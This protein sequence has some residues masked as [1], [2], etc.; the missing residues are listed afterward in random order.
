MEAR[1]KASP[2]TYPENMRGSPYVVKA[3]KLKWTVEVSACEFMCVCDSR[4]RGLL[5]VLGAPQRTTLTVS[6]PVGRDMSAL[7]PPSRYASRTFLYKM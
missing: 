1:A 7:G 4:G 3:R 2:L 5:P 6:H